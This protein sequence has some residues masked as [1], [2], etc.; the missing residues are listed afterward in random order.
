MFPKLNSNLFSVFF[1]TKQMLWHKWDYQID[2]YDILGDKEESVEAK[3][4][5]SKD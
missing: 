2:Q 5:Q 4:E 1:H 3:I